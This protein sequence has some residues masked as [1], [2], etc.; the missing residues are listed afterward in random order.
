[1]EGF[2]ILFMNYVT[3]KNYD[4]FQELFDANILITGDLAR[5]R[6]ELEWNTWHLSFDKKFIKKLSINDLQ[7]F[8]AHLVETR[9]KQ[10]KSEGNCASVTFYVW[11]DIMSLNLCFDF[12]SGK[13]IALP[14]TKSHLLNI[15]DSVDHILKKFLTEAQ[16]IAVHGNWAGFTVINP[17]D[18]D[19]NDEEDDDDDDFILD[20]YVTTLQI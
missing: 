17:G 6:E 3:I 4:D 11:F 1:M 5:Q 2:N 13:D 7:Q 14:F 18:P 15:V 19:W 20:V 8:V 16:R 12:L 10:L 9:I